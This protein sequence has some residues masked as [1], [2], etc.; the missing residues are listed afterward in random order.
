M[1][2]CAGGFTSLADLEAQHDPTLELSHLIR[3]QRSAAVFRSELSNCTGRVSCNY[4][5]M[6]QAA[7]NLTWL[8]TH[9]TICR[10]A[11]QGSCCS[12]MPT[13]AAMPCFLCE[14]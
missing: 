9:D 4:G 13:L 6:L 7:Y 5:I 1:H 8:T 2:G 14:K 10:T 11:F 12:V 3:N